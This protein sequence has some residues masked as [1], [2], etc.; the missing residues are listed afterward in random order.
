MIRTVLSLILFA[1]LLAAGCSQHADRLPPGDLLVA[2]GLYSVS[3]SGHYE[4]TGHVFA[5]PDHTVRARVAS[6]DDALGGHQNL[7]RLEAEW[8]GA[9][10]GQVMW[11][12]VTR[13]AVREVAY[14]FRAGGQH[15]LPRPVASLPSFSEAFEAAWRE[16]SWSEPA[17]ARRGGDWQEGKSV[18]RDEPRIVYG[19][20]LYVGRS[21]VDFEQPFRRE[22]RVTGIERVTVPA[23][24]FEAYVIDSEIEVGGH[25]PGEYLRIR[26]HLVPGRGIVKHVVS[27]RSQAIEHDGEPAGWFQVEQRVE[28]IGD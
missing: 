18:L 10:Y 11:Y 23:G 1:S 4:E 13:D 14:E 17:V 22:S 15:V 25:H 19:L 9:E 28:L 24:T 12:D 6:Q 27:G 16:L 8:I 21:W 5:G 20:P 2:E 26:R 7:T 3:L